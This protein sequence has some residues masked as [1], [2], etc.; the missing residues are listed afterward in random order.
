MALTYRMLPVAGGAT[1]NI[2][3]GSGSPTIRSYSASAGT[4]IDAVGDVNG[5]QSALASQGFLPVCLSGPTG[6]RPNFGSTT[7]GPPPGRGTLYLD[8]TLSVVAIWDGSNWRNVITGA[9]V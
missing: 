5:D 9:S 3:E 6:S 4:T 7:L 8:T 1:G 2:G